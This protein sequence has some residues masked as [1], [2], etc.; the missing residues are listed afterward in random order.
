[1][2]K[3]PPSFSSAIKDTWMKKFQNAL[4][5]YKNHRYDKF[6]QDDSPMVCMKKKAT[7]W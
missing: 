6:S 3:F 7:I 1:M 2:P 4:F 5:C